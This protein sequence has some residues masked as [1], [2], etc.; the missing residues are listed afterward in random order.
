MYSYDWSLYKSGEKEMKV[1][2]HICFPN[3]PNE[4]MKI[5]KN[6][7]DYY[8]EVDGIAG[9]VLVDLIIEDDSLVIC[10]N[11]GFHCL[12]IPLE[13]VTELLEEKK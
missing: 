12:Y 10:V 3:N 7:L 6:L 13:K 8:V 1:K 2:A 4:H 11:K 5:L 9:E